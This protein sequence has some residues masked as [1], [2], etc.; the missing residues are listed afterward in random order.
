MLTIFILCGIGLILTGLFYRPTKIQRE[1]DG[2][3]L[4]PKELYKEVDGRT[5]WEEIMLQD[6]MYGD[7]RWPWQDDNDNGDGYY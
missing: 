7:D 2:V 5:V 6:A 3:S 4:N 1:A